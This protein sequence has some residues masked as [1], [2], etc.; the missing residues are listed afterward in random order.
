MR[1]EVRLFWEL[2][3]QVTILWFLSLYVL[4]DGHCVRCVVSCCVVVRGGMGWGGVC[5][6]VLCVVWYG[7]VWCDVAYCRVESCCDIVM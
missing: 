5:C 2:H 1:I 7:V 4:L 3:E 6:G